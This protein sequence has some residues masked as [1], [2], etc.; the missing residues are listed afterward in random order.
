MHAHYSPPQADGDRTGSSLGD[1]I[2]S[3]VSSSVIPE[4]QLRIYE[5]WLSKLAAVLG[6]GLQDP[7]EVVTKFTGMV[8]ANQTN[9]LIKSKQQKIFRARI[10]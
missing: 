6:G 4:E 1:D 5:D 3:Q 8:E 2:D 9:L 7:E 10:S